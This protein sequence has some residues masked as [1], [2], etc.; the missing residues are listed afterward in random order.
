ME[1]LNELINIEST[2]KHNN[3]KELLNKYRKITR[4]INKYSAMKIEMEKNYTIDDGLTLGDAHSIYLILGLLKSQLN[5]CDNVIE[6]R[7]KFVRIIPS[8][9]K[10][11]EVVDGIN[12][13]KEM[14][15]DILENGINLKKFGNGHC[16]EHHFIKIKN[17]LVCA[18]CMASTKDYNAKT[19]EVE[20][21]TLCAQRKGL[22]LKDVE[23][24]DLTLYNVLLSEQYDSLNK[25]YNFSSSK[26]ILNDICQKIMIAKMMDRKEYKISDNHIINPE[27]LSYEKGQKIINEINRKKQEIINSNSKHKDLLLELCDVSMNEVLILRGYSIEELLKGITTGEEITVLAKAYYNISNYEYRINSGYF[28]NQNDAANYQCLTANKQINQKILD[29]KF[30]RQG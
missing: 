6:L 19:S 14:E 11:I 21:L 10:Y 1:R 15:T 4:N 9:S 16:D 28:E 13:L 27:Y 7:N 26:N 20:F 18:K 23:E 5:A 8:L 24:S 17:H 3:F 25:S 12:S 29:M 22:F 30:K 2:F